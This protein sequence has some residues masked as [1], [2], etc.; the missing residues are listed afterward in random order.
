MN[1]NSG[2]ALA[3]VLFISSAT[4][5]LDVFSAVNSS[6]WT[7]YNFANDA[8]AKQALRY[9]V[10]HAVVIT[11]LINLVGSSISRSY[12]PIAGATVASVY[13]WWLYEDAVKKGEKEKSEAWSSPA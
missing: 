9:Y 11:V 10:T 2:K 6:P 4:N 7:A 12:W 8:K 5:A 13:M 3:A 1:E